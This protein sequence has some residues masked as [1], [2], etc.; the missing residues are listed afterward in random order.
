M[1]LG[2]TLVAEDEGRPMA[3]FK[4]VHRPYRQRHRPR[5][6]LAGR[7]APKAAYYVEADV[8]SDV[9]G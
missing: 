6:L 8:G 9:D 2:L 3:L 5:A 1:N 4:E 7:V